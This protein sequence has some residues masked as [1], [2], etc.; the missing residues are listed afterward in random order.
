VMTLPLDEMV[1]HCPA[2]VARFDMARLVVVALVKS[3]DVEKSAVVVAF[4]ATS[5]VAK[6]DVLVALV[7]SALVAPSEVEVALVNKR[8][9]PDIAVVEAK[10]M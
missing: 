2:W 9:V 5:E 8:L 1:R 10:L 3:A 6:S 7:R 4:V